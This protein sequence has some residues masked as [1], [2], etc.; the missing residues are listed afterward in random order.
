MR[1]KDIIIDLR[2]ELEEKNGTLFEQEGIIEKFNKMRK[3]HLEFRKV[4]VE[5]Y[6]NGMTHLGPQGGF[7][8]TAT[9]VT[10]GVSSN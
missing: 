6:R 4:M 10:G 3:L 9:T 1:L 8:S 5:N 2:K 7:V